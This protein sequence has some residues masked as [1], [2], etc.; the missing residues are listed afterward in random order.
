MTVARRGDKIGR[1]EGGA[2]LFMRQ[3]DER[4][5]AILDRLTEEK[6]VYVSDLSQ[7]FDVSEVTIRK[8]LKELEERGEL[9]RVHG[10][11]TVVAPGKVAVES[12]LDEL[13]QIHMAEKRAIARAAYERI[14]DGDA[15]LLDA[16]TTTRELACLLGEGT[17]KNITVITTA[18]QIAQKLAP[19]EH[20]QVIQIGGIIRRS[21]LTAMGPMATEALRGIH[22]D[23]AFIG[24][25]GIDP[26]AGL[27]T[28]NM[29]ECEVKRHMI[30]SA[31]Q[32]FVLADSSKMCCI[33]LGVICPVNR[34]D[35]VVTDAAAPPSV[36]KRLEDCGV[37]VV[38]AQ[39]VKNV[40]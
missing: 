1:K 36:V 16:S 19:C 20:I 34:V 10:G 31:T 14:C 40:F 29:L 8:D 32:S 11:A 9:R 24:V 26:L 35:Y 22:A 28:Q 33:A 27:T 4:K 15:L 21:L 5:Q 12:T 23:K 13:I 6:R 39:A 17:H 3:T 38:S 25:N 30:E 18:L 7:E 2:F 37:E